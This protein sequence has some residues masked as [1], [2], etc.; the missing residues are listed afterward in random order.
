[1]DSFWK[2]S[3]SKE[4]LRIDA[5]H[6]ILNNLHR[7]KRQN[8]DNFSE[9]L[10]YDLKRIVSGLSSDRINARKGYF[11]SLVEMLQMFPEEANIPKVYELMEKHL[12]MKGSK[13]V[14]VVVVP[15]IF[16]ILVHYETLS[17]GP[18]TCYCNPYL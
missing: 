3:D 7:Q 10:A 8:Q 14:S 6:K 13:S 18:R 11:V 12:S 1:M 16:R 2:L 9:N 17:L 4:K 5:S 15:F